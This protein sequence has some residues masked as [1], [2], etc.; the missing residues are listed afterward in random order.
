MKPQFVLSVIAVSVTSSCACAAYADVESKVLQPQS[1]LTTPSPVI[2]YDDGRLTARIHKLSLGEVLRSLGAVTGA[3]VTLCDPSL[4][5]QT[6]SASVEAEPYAQGIRAILAGFSYAIYPHQG[7]R[8]PA[9][10]VLSTPRASGTKHAWVSNTAIWVKG[11]TVPSGF[12]GANDGSDMG[13][14]ENVDVAHGENGYQED[15][16]ITTDAQGSE[17]LIDRALEAIAGAQTIENDVIEQLVG[18]QDPRATEV[19]V[20]AASG[21]TDGASRATAVEALWR[22]A[23]DHAF[24]DQGAIASLEQLAND[25]DLR[26]STIARRALQDKEQFQQRNAVQ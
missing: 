23:A 25:S 22:H 6:V 14:A 5:R 1:Q 7:Q 19:L 8:L 17:A 24:T 3:R 21:S 15:E 4:A 20:H 9:V 12:I 2:R 10:T 16:N 26:V 13:L 18:A 11:G